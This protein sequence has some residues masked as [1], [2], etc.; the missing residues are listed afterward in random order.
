MSNPDKPWL[1][2]YLSGLNAA[3]GSGGSDPLSQLG[4]FDQAALWMNNYCQANPLSNTQEG[5]N[6]LYRELLARVSVKK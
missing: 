3:I 5:G 4:S 6:K 2:G 1:A